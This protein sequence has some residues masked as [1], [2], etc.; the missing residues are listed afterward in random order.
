MKK[1]AQ[2]TAYK[3]IIHNKSFSLILTQA[4]KVFICGSDFGETI[5]LTEECKENDASIEF[6][7][8]NTNDLFFNLTANETIVDIAIGGKWSEEVIE[9]SKNE[10][11]DLIMVAAVTQD[12]SLFVRGGILLMLPYM[13]KE[14]V[15]GSKEHR[16][17]RVKIEHPRNKHWKA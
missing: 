11:E 14:E 5:R 16:C 1:P 4:G 3:K 10:K 2:C 7:E 6:K 9:D 15:K 17:K 12:G 8:V 13:C